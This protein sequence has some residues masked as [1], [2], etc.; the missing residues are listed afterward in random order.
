MN[1]TEQTMR[2]YAVTDRSWLAG[3]TLQACVEEALLGG[4][5]C[6]Q[7]REKMLDDKDFLSEAKQIGALC[8]AYHVPFIVNDNVDVA[9]QAQADGVHIG[10]HD[11]SAAQTRARLGADKILGVSVQTVAQAVQAERDGADYL[12][13][14][15][16]FPT[17]TKGDADAVSKA[18]LEAICSA[19]TIPV[20]AIGGITLENLPE[21]AGTG[22]NGAAV[23][24]AI[25]AAEDIQ[26]AAAALRKIS[27]TC[28]L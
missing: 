15:A 26:G 16:V 24:S 20:T 23:V 2:V 11:A 5:S 6:V 9:L 3:R 7:L 8:K 13:V 17:T 18:T 14:G 25:F 19:V 27:D 4:V 21:L 28:F 1:C 22:V 10:Q 12:G